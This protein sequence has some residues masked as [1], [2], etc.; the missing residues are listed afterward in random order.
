DSNTACIPAATRI[1]EKAACLVG[2]ASSGDGDRVRCGDRDSPRRTSTE[3]STEDPGV[4][5]KGQP[6]DPQ[7]DVSSVSAPKSTTPNSSPLGAV[8]VPPTL[9][10]SPPSTDN[11]FPACASSVLLWMVV[12]AGVGPRHPHATGGATLSVIFPPRCAAKVAPSAERKASG[13][14]T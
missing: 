5:R 6:P 7:V 4:T 10:P 3:A 9:C 8:S 14:L 12:G 13:L 2:T 1:T 11:T